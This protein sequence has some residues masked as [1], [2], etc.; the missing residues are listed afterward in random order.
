METTPIT[1]TTAAPPPPAKET[2]PIT[3]ITAG[4]SCLLCGNPGDPAAP[5]GHYPTPFI[6]DLVKERC[7]RGPLIYPLVMGWGETQEICVCR[8]CF[9]QL[10]RR[11]HAA[12]RTQPL[13]MDATLLQTIVPGFMRQQDSRTRERMCAALAT[14]GNS[15][16]RSFE[17][18]QTLLQSNRLES[19]WAHNLRTEFFSHKTTARLIRKS[20]L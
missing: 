13:P 15:Y 4:N 5:P 2:T 9:H 7:A 20:G 6:R 11:K 19:W 3:I 8:L 17:A 14:P 12:S 10:K 1:A 16:S 18:L